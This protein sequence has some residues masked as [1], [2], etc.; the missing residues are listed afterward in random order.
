MLCYILRRDKIYTTLKTLKVTIA[1]LQTKDSRLNTK[2]I[3]NWLF[4]TGNKFAEKVKK[5][6][7][8]MINDRN[9]RNSTNG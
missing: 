8:L 2:N 5:F 4:T 3:H 1:T 9:V 7:M 6:E